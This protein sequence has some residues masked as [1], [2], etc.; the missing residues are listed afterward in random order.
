M[1]TFRMFFCR[2]HN[3]YVGVKFMLV[4][5]MMGVIRSNIAIGEIFAQ[6]VF[7][8]QGLSKLLI[9]ATTLYACASVKIRLNLAL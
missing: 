1:L 7:T 4:T 6:S 5:G 8:G 3:A 9:Y 2:N